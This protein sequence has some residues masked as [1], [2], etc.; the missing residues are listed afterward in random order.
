MQRTIWNVENLLETILQAMAIH[1]TAASRYNLACVTVV[2]F[3]AKHF[4]QLRQSPHLQLSL[5][6]AS[7]E[8]LHE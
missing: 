6:G 3:L 5:I 8:A 4:H 2:R 7:L 1:G